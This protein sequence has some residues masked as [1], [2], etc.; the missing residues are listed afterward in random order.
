MKTTKHNRLRG[1]SPAALRA[2]LMSTVAMLL[3]AS[4]L[5]VTSSY[6]WFVLSTAPEV[7][8]INT[9][10]GAN[11]ALEIALLDSQSWAD[12][13]LL[14]MGDIDE[15]VTDTAAA[16]TAANLTWGNLVNLS[17]AAYG[18]SNI[19]LQPS[20]LYIQDKGIE[21]GEQTYGIN[22]LLL[23]TPIY[24]EDG[25]ITGLDREKTV[26]S[27]FDGTG[28]TGDGK[29]VRAIGTAAQMSVY[30]LGM[31]AARAQVSTY[32]SAAASKTSTA[33]AD[34][35]G[36]IVNVV[37]K[38]VLSS[39]ATFTG[40]DV[41]P[42][43]ELAK[44]LKDALA[45]IELALRNTFAGYITTKNSGI[46]DEAYESELAYIN[47]TAHSLADL[48][49]K[50]SGITTMVPEMGT[51][52]ENLTANQTKVDA[53]IAE[54][55]TLQTQTNV[56]WND[57]ENAMN[58]L[59]DYTKMLLCGKTMEEVELAYKGQMK[60]ESGSIVND[61]NN[62]GGVSAVVSMLDITNASVT[63]TPG[64]GVLADVADFTGNYT[65]EVEADLTS[66]R[67]GKMDV[68]LKT[69]TVKNPTYL[70]DCSQRMGKATL[71]AATGNSAITDYYGYA[72]DLAF[73]SNAVSTTG[74][75]TSGLMLQTEAINRI[76]GDEAV[77]NTKLQGGGSY[78][79]FTTTAGLSA[80]KM[81]KLMDG[82]R[83]VFMDKEQKVL[84]LAKL[85]MTL[86]Q[87]VYAPVTTGEGESAAATGQ[88]YLKGF[89][90]QY[91]NS[92]II[93]A[94]AYAAL[95]DTSSVVFVEGSR[96]VTAKLYLYDFEMTVSTAH[97]NTTDVDAG[98]ATVDETPAVEDETTGTTTEKKYTGGITI[99]DK[100][101]DAKITDLTQ[102]EAKIVTAL[103]YLDGSVVNNA[104]V[105][106]NNVQ[107]MTGTL[108]LQFSSD[109]QLMPA[110]NTAL[111]KGSADNEQNGA[112]E[113]GTVDENG[114]ESGGN[115]TQQTT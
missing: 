7:S 91:Q 51:Y 14:D 48:K 80:T 112:T 72:I 64:S 69:A 86:G 108:N 43:L 89:G 28:F 78:M 29:G 92:D 96:Q 85:D 88:Y 5:L 30:Q 66:L 47:D 8:G 42:L 2:K 33:L 83:V 90:D 97:G 13:S 26:N 114:G 50:Y 107:S 24:G 46:S 38:K 103:V 60:D 6:A 3:V 67:L 45:Q 53:S 16:A 81:V 27:I 87:D 20:R 95:P 100:K 111:K 44:G 101:A 76:Y 10:V 113:S 23:K 18:L 79:T 110:D 77:E 34:N 55:E 70:S 4:T 41:T 94:E 25:R 82:I 63:V 59:V 49:T 61:P 9:Q 35:G 36:G 71:K 73:R 106:A 17:D 68:P 32:S 104:T 105:A 22:A 109:A 98:V 99:K 93:S 40:S 1:M 56:A 84:A 102:D 54:F 12:L 21:S 15:S 19:T 37:L 115:E 65:A 75:S 52:I 57:I 74:G 39:D 58:G 62:E 31:N 11:G